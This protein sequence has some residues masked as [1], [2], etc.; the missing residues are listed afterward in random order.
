MLTLHRGAPGAFHSEHIGIRQSLSITFCGYL[1]DFSAAVGRLER[2]FH[3][4]VLWAPDV[5]YQ[6]IKYHH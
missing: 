5:C 1:I 6:A 2:T 3:G 4:V